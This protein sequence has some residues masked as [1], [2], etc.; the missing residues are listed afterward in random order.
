MVIKRGLELIFIH[1][2]FNPPTM[3]VPDRLQLSRLTGVGYLHHLSKTRQLSE[4]YFQLS[5]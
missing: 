2:L 3:D 1:G 4:A 5:R